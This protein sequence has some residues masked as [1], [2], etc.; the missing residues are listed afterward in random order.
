M[1]SPTLKTRLTQLGLRHTSDALDDLIAT[2]TKRRWGPAELME[3][4][5]DEETKDRARRGV[6]RR[7]SRSRL[8]TMRT[9][10]DFDWG[11]PKRIDRT[12]VEGAL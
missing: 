2:A 6:E 9:M 12:A 3:A 8:G 7:L 1:N 10:A 4:I 11:W 5:A